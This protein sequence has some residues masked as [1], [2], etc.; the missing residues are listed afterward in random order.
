MNRNI[1]MMEWLLQETFYMNQNQ[2]LG[3]GAF[4]IEITVKEKVKSIEGLVQLPYLAVAKAL[5]VIPRTLAQNCE[6]DVMRIVA[7]LRNKHEKQEDK[8]KIFY[9]IDEKKEKWE[10]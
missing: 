10:I 4:E 5:E 3:G 2:F 6:A 7:D 1:Q 8:E 9:G